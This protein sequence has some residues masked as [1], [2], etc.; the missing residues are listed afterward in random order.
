MSRSGRLIALFGRLALA[1]N[2]PIIITN[3]LLP[4]DEPMAS[5]SSL[6]NGDQRPA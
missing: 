5:K 4:I 2:H 6:M 3:N 1:N